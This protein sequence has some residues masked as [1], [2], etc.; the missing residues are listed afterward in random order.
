[1]PHVNYF[2]LAVV[3]IMIL[4]PFWVYSM[5]QRARRRA[6]QKVSHRYAALSQEIAE[7]SD[8]AATNVS[9]V[10]Q[11]YESKNSLASFRNFD[12][13]KFFF[14]YVSERHRHIANL[15]KRLDTNRVVSKTL[16]GWL[17]VQRGQ[18]V[19]ELDYIEADKIAKM[20]Y[21]QFL[22]IEEEMCDKTL[23]WF[24]S[25]LVCDVV[26]KVNVSYVSPAGR[27]RYADT[28]SFNEDRVRMLLDKV[29]SMQANAQSMDD[30]KRRQRS[31]MTPKLRYQI[32]QR[33]GFKCVLCGRSMADGIK[34]LEVDHIKPVS[35]GGLTEPGNLR[36]LCWDCNQGKKDRYIEGGVN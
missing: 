13:D 8:K 24:R 32:M 25:S 5:Q 14:K 12:A 33:D 29:L 31:L 3:L 6:V 4:V 22:K 17:S 2:L 20:S 19:S 10:E 27:N 26:W 35:K 1:M 34:Q 11:I 23:S 21:E 18:D 28:F 9:P 16:D 7:L 30:F 36:T 15:L